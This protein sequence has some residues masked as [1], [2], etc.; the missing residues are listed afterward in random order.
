M[1]R[2]LAYL[3]IVLGLGFTFS[4]NAEAKEKFM[5]I[6][7]GSG[8]YYELV[9]SGLGT[10]YNCDYEVSKNN[11]KKLYNQLRS[12]WSKLS[13]GSVRKIY[14]SDLLKITKKPLKNFT[15]S[16]IISTKKSNDK[17]LMSYR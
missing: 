6:K 4:V 14:H 17:I 7:I 1:K 2:L 3:F 5:C 9:P 11:Q 13:G 16:K 12:V 8:G 15:T 10:A